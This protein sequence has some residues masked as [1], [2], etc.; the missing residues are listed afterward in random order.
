M[1]HR[2]KWIPLDRALTDIQ[3]ATDC[4][5]EAAHH[6]LVS[7]CVEERA[8]T[9]WRLHQLGTRSIPAR[10]WLGASVS[11]TINGI[12]KASG[13]RM[14]GV[15]ISDDDLQVLFPPAPSSTR[16]KSA[17]KLL[18]GIDALFACYPDGIPDHVDNNTILAVTFAWLKANRSEVHMGNRTMLRAAGRAK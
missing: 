11:E 10:D 9:R 7:V 3:A 1:H 4:A 5:R 2:N 8:R 6:M 14:A 15:E 16:K 13:S 18:A 17:R 12:V